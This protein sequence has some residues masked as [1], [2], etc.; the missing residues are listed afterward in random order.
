MQEPYQQPQTLQQ[1][2]RTLDLQKQ[3]AFVENLTHFPGN[4]LTDYVD[5]RKSVTQPAFVNG[6]VHTSALLCATDTQPPA[7]QDPQP[8]LQGFELQANTSTAFD[9]FPGCDDNVRPNKPI[10]TSSS[11]EHSIQA[12]E[13]GLDQVLLYGVDPWVSV[14]QYQGQGHETNFTVTTQDTNLSTRKYI[15][16]TFLH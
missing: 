8:S 4:K 14:S 2:A 5:L 15:M 9:P 13:S 11:S 10:S 1:P 7:P 6:D 16:Y 3:Q 12:T